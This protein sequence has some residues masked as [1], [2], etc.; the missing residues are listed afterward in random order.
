M[1]ILFHHY[2]ELLECITEIEE[3]MM[4]TGATPN[5]RK[6]NNMKCS[7]IKEE[8]KQMEEIPVTTLDYFYL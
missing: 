1:S 6:K 3:M 2:K 8:A 5:T 7:S 4:T